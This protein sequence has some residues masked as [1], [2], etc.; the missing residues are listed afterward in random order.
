MFLIILTLRQANTRRKLFLPRLVL[1]LLTA[2]LEAALDI[3]RIEGRTFSYEKVRIWLAASA[4]ED[5]PALFCRGG[6]TPPSFFCSESYFAVYPTGISVVLKSTPDKSALL[7]SV[8]RKIVIPISAPLNFAPST[9][10]FRKFAFR[11]N[12]F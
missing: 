1:R 11:S 5:S 3:V 2:T 12:A 8:S 9:T 6:F 4:A 7:K 10:A